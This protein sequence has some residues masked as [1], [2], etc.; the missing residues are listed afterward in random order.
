MVKTT[1]TAIQNK[2]P[3]PTRNGNRLSSAYDLAPG[4]GSYQYG[5]Q[6]EHE[7]RHYR[8]RHHRVGQS[9]W[10]YFYNDEALPTQPS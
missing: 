3:G 5:A 4:E 10:S 6:P 1:L 9:I 8:D 2:Q 7:Q